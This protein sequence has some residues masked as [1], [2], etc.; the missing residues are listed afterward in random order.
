MK[1]VRVLRKTTFL[2][3]ETTKLYHNHPHIITVINTNSSSG[4]IHKADRD[5]SPKS[6]QPKDSPPST[7]TTKPSSSCS[8]PTAEEE[9]ARPHPAIP[10]TSLP[11]STPP[12]SAGPMPISTANMGLPD[13]AP[14]LGCG[15]GR[16]ETCR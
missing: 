14:Q 10:S 4:T 11:S 3:Q 7:T 15:W 16:A 13:W 1:V 12:T 9:M 5:L 8:R 6:M 2:L